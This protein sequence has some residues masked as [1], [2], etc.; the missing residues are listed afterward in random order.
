MEYSQESG[1]VGPVSHGPD[2]TTDWRNRI[3]LTRGRSQESEQA[4]QGKRETMV[5]ILP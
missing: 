2:Q 5:G 1:R 4:G 3:S